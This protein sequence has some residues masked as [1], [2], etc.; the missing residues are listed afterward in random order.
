MKWMV[1]AVLGVLV[2]GRWYFKVKSHSIFDSYRGKE[3]LWMV[4]YRVILGGIQ[5]GVM[6]LYLFEMAWSWMV[7]PMPFVVSMVGS[8]LAWT[9][10]AWIFWAHRALGDNFSPSVGKA[11]NLVKEG[12]YRWIRHPIY[13]GYMLLFLAIFLMTGWWVFCLLGEMILTSLVVWRLPLEEAYL[14][15]IFGEEY[16]EYAAKTGR[17]L[18]I[19]H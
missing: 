16:R 13:L 17:F 19:I 8:V 7:W 4:V 18:P 6:G 14:E 12:P 11:Y 9:S 1:V 5:G 3:P 2:M 10:V 15:E